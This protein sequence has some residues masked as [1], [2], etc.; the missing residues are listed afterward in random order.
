MTRVSVRPRRRSTHDISLEDPPK[1]YGLKL[2][3]GFLE[4]LQ[5]IAAVE[6]N[7]LRI[8]TAQKSGDHNPFEG[9]QPQ[10]TWH[11]GMGLEDFS[12]DP[13]RYY[14]GKFLWSQT[15]GQL[16]PMLL[17]KWANTDNRDYNM[18]QPGDV[19]W[20]PLYSDTK[21][22]SSSF[23]VAAQDSTSYDADKA[24]ILMRRVGNP[25]PI[26]VQI[27]SDDSGPDALIGNATKQKDITDITDVVSTWE[28]FDWSSTLTLTHTTTYHI[29]VYGGT[30]DN[31]NNHWEVGVDTTGVSSKYSS[32]GSAWTSAGFTMYYRVVDADAAV[33]CHGFFLDGTDMYMVTQPA[34]GDSELLEWDETNDEWDMCPDLSDDGSDALSGIVK[35]VAVSGNLA[36]FARGTG[37]SDETIFVFDKDGADHKGRDDGTAG[38]KADVLLAYNDPVNGPQLARFENDNWYWSRSDVKAYGTNLVFGT[39]IKFPQGYDGLNMVYYNSQVW[40]RV[41]NE[42]WAVSN[43]R[44]LPLNA[45]MNAVIEQDTYDA[46]L[47]VQDLFLYLGWAFSIER[48]YQGVLD[49]I[50]YWHGAGIPD[51]YQ[52]RNTCY[53]AAPGVIFIGVDGGS[54]NRSCVLAMT[55][56]GGVYH[57]IWEAWETGQ[58]I[59]NLWIQP[60]NGTTSP[61]RLWI[62]VGTDTVYIDFPDTSMNPTKDSGAAYCWEAVCETAAFSYGVEQPKKLFNELDVISKNLGEDTVIDVDYQIDDYVGSTTASDW[63]FAGTLARSPL[64]TI[65]LK[66]GNRHKIRFRFRMRTTDRTTPPIMT[67]SVLDGLVTIPNKRQWNLKVRLGGTV[68]GR[69]DHPAEELYLWLSD[70]AASAKLLHM[71]CTSETMDDTYVK[72]MPGIYNREYVSVVRKKEGGVIRLTLREV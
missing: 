27:W 25:D 30:N 61:M 50:G 3:G 15:P 54:A 8:G 56:Q 48:L 19:H 38:N 11:G 47:Y 13:N 20:R 67:S 59:R 43:D 49:D 17:W 55:E 10:D 57:P 34:T 69:P 44:P 32:D 23:T 14:H 6:D 70:A 37:G 12:D 71:R 72:V 31:K 18:H 29:V 41:T 53:A 9:H 60:Q 39:D 68:R 2:D 26:T 64:D 58:R 62:S 42:L 28:V 52:G 35:S 22:I 63:I 7:T 24:Y 5:E 21:Y 40:V 33:K 45:G 65:P 16:H 36:H 1:K 66:L 51:G 4:G 46:P